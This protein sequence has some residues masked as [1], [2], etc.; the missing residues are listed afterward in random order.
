MENSKTTQ[1]NKTAESIEV[2]T[3]QKIIN[4]KKE[5]ATNLIENWKKESGI[6]FEYALPKIGEDTSW[7][8]LHGKYHGWDITLDVNIDKNQIDS[9]GSYAKKDGYKNINYR[10]MTVE[11]LL[12]AKPINK[13]LEAKKELLQA[14]AEYAQKLYEIADKYG[15]IPQEEL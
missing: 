5:I 2:D 3:T 4:H 10:E 15:V 8:Y 14:K 13:E 12:T 1:E 9:Y 7:F 6:N 11:A